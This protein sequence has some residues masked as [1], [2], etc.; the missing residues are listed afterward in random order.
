MKL[1][2]KP[3]NICGRSFY[4]PNCEYS[5]GIMDLLRKRSRKAFSSDDIEAL[6]NR[7]FKLIIEGEKHGK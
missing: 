4:T 1:H 3:V 7:G 5:E 6:K 2:L